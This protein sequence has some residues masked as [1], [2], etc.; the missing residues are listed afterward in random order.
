MDSSLVMSN[1]EDDG[2]KSLCN[3]SMSSLGGCNGVDDGDYTPS[4]SSVSDND[5][6]D[7]VLYEHDTPPDEDDGDDENSNHLQSVLIDG[8][9]GN[10]SYSDSKD[11]T[12]SSLSDS[13]KSNSA[14]NKGGRSSCIY[15]PLY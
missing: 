13:D 11:D 10:N 14:M 12:L 5:S 4:S 6:Q 1:A 2:E 9:D 3:E 8:T 15:C 7:N